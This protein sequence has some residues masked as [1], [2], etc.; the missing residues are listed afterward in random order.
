VRYGGALDDHIEDLDVEINNPVVAFREGI[1]ALLRLPILTF[2][3]LG[4]AEAPSL[5]VGPIS[6]VI[7]GIVSLLTL[8]SAVVTIIVGWT[9]L[10]EFLKGIIQ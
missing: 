3:W 5:Y 8:L 4:L 6:R 7:G 2:H 10:V 9:P 1:Q